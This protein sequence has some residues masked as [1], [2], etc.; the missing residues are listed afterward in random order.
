MWERLTAEEIAKAYRTQRRTGRWLLGEPVDHWKW[1]TEPKE[2]EH[3]SQPGS[4]S[5]L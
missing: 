4:D 3:A 2:Q 1:T 5:R